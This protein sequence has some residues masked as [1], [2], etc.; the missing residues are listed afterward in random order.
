MAF[1]SCCNPPKTPE[2]DRCLSEGEE[3]PEVPAIERMA[4]DLAF[5]L[6][7]LSSAKQ[8]VNDAWHERDYLKEALR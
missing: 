7:E 2:A 1:Q 3:P 6:R 5:A 8:K 4:S